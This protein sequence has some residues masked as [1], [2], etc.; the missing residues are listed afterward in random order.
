M[1]GDPLERDSFFEEDG[2]LMTSNE[3][4]RHSILALRDP[5]V[6]RP[7]P[8][9]GGHERVQNYALYYEGVS[10]SL[11]KAHPARAG[12]ERDCEP[13]K[14]YERLSV[15]RAHTM[16]DFEKQI[17]ELKKENFNLK[18][19]IYFLEEQVQR[20]CDNSSEELHRMNI[21]L[22]VEVESLKHEYQEKQTLL[23][24]ASKAM[25]SF[26]GDHN[27]TVQQLKDDH[28]K[29]LQDLQD[30]SRRKAQA[31]EDELKQEKAELEK[32]CVILDQE[33]RQRFN[34]EERL[35]AVKEQYNKSMGI[36]E[37]RD[38]IVQCLNE[39][40]RSKDALITQ[41]EKQMNTMI[42]SDRP[43]AGKE[44]G[45][46]LE[47]DRSHSPGLTCRDC[48][49]TKSS[50]E[51]EDNV[52]EWRKK[53]QE[54]GNVVNELQQKLEDSKA[55][56]AAEEKNSLKRDKAIQ[57]LTL[58]L[59]KKSKE[60]E[61]LRKDIDNLNAASAQARESSLH[62]GSQ[63]GDTDY[64]KLIFTIQAQQ[65]LCSRL[66]QYE[67]ESGSLQKELDAIVM[68]RKWLE[69]DIQSNQEL[70]KILEAQIMERY[71]ESDSMSFLGDQTSYLSI[72]LDHL[73][74]NNHHIDGSVT[75]PLMKSAETQTVFTNSQNEERRYRLQDCKL[76][77][78]VT[79]ENA[80]EE[81]VTAV[82]THPKHE[83]PER[84]QNTASSSIQTEPQFYADRR[85]LADAFAEETSEG[86]KN[87]AKEVLG[88]S[89]SLPSGKSPHAIQ[90]DKQQ[91]CF[92]N[93]LTKS[94]IPVL[95]KSPL[96]KRLKT[97]T[98]LESSRQI[99]QEL[100][101]E[102]P[103]VWSEKMEAGLE[104]SKQNLPGDLQ[105]EKLSGRS[106]QTEADLESSRQILQG[107]IHPERLSGR[108][109]QTKAGL[110]S[111]RLILQGERL[112]GHMEADLTSREHERV[113]LE[114]ELRDENSRLLEELKF[115][116]LEIETLKSIKEKLEDTRQGWNVSQIE[117]W[118]QIL[119]EGL[120][121]ER[122][123]GQGDLQPER[124]KELLAQMEAGLASRESEP[125]CPEREL[126]EENSR[127]LEELKC[128][129]LEIGALKS[130]PEGTS[131]V[132]DVPNDEI[133]SS[134]QI[135]LGE[136]QVEK[137]SSEENSE[138]TEA[139][140][141]SRQNEYAYLEKELREENSRLLE[142]LKF[143]K[144]EIGALK[145]NKEKPES[146]LQGWDVSSPG[147]DSSQFL[148]GELQPERPSGRSEQMEA[149]F[150]CREKEHV[151]HEKELREEN[152]RLLEQLKL[153]KC[154][155]GSLK[156]N[157]EKSEST[158]Q[159]WDVSYSGGIEFSRQ[160]LHGG[161]Q[162]GR[163][164]GQGVL[165]P[166]GLCG[167][168]VLQPMRLNGE[169]GLQP[170]RLSRQGDPQPEA[171]S[172]Q[173][174]LQ[175]EG[176]SEQG[177][178]QPM[179][180]NGQIVLQP[181]RLNEQVGLQPMSLN[182]QVGLQPEGLSEQGG[183]QPERL[184]GQIVLQ[185][186]RL[187]EQVGL[188]PMRLNEQV[189][190]QPERLNG[191]IVLQL[192]RLNGQVG[193]QSKSLNGQ[194][195]LQPERLSGQ[196]SLQPVRLSG[197]GSLQPEGLIGQGGLQP[198]GLNGLPEQFKCSQIKG[199]NLQPV[200][201]SG[202]CT[203][204][205]SDT[206]EPEKEKRDSLQQTFRNSKLAG[207]FKSACFKEENYLSR[208]VVYENTNAKSVL[209]IADIAEGDFPTQSLHKELQVE[210][211]R[212]AEQLKHAQM[213][214]EKH[215][216]REGNLEKANVSNMASGYMLEGDLAMRSRIEELQL[217]NQRLAGQLKRE[218]MDIEK[219][220]ASEVILE[221]TNVRSDLDTLEGDLA[222]RSL[223][224]ELQLENQQL[225]EQ[226]KSA[227]LEIEKLREEKALEDIDGSFR[228]DNP[229][230][231]GRDSEHSFLDKTIGNAVRFSEMHNGNSNFEVQI[232]SHNFTCQNLAGLCCHHDRFCM[233][234]ANN[235]ETLIYQSSSFK[236]ISTVQKE[237]KLLTVS[238]RPF[239]DTSL[240]K[241]DL[242]VQ[243]Q[244]R[245]LSHQRQKI[246]E[247]HNL[248][249]VC[250]KNFINAIKAF[251]DLLS[252]ASLD[253]NIALG[254]QE[255]LAQTVEWLK[256]LEYKLSNAYYGE[257]DANSDH[258]ADSLLYTPSRLVPGHKMWADK[259]GCHVLGLV[260]DYNALR[261]QILESKSVLEETEAFIDHGVQTAVLNMTE[262][263]GNVFFEKL[264]R[265][266][267]SLEEASCLL[268][269]LWRVS[270]P[271][272]T[273]SSYNVR[274]VEES[275][276][277][278]TRLRKRVLEQ[279]KLLSGM[280]KRVYS[281]NQMKE[282]IEK[283][284]LNQLAM[285]HKILKQA[286]GNLEVQVVD[287]N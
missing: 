230:M 157:Q 162:L 121:S 69:K 173:R 35:L 252:T 34:A 128:A 26:A 213:D 138:Q 193:L 238:H 206:E 25:E 114:K 194:V 262:H 43:N 198:E 286:K 208:E 266:K 271:L 64:R 63:N 87:G 244:A 68:L 272:Q 201:D 140:L 106:E 243:S 55:G 145:S 65:D 92:S 62:E 124:L 77:P 142:E 70:R 160:I 116:K 40:L 78:S 53:V 154:E 57:G 161:L 31:L 104:S 19:R 28:L 133:E 12:Y 241:Y 195:G 234:C 246:K 175:P 83:I 137:L 196:G 146:M 38:W 126:R 210:N 20:H 280:V 27:V 81:S 24:R 182:E 76:N 75:R 79:V 71:R 256:E 184:N 177:G 282:D 189:G 117:S 152:S 49:A 29:Q 236:K 214:I 39:T 188:Q 168:V 186:M 200:E 100:Q 119:Q 118:R 139:G 72:C 60:N 240:S 3:M 253:S 30:A 278:T 264:N 96:S 136:L 165:Q 242:L 6:G 281:E 224:K 89:W 1:D 9:R 158:V 277:E 44:V 101:P 130:K 174:D 229:E 216:T 260:E 46:L 265:T 233:E 90:N 181:M 247:S 10:L 11:E 250:S 94:R 150:A 131:Q 21:E 163:L 285:T 255:Q 273:H 261:K 205:P 115:A 105:P 212:L 108:S 23:I 228:L 61:K 183:L 263:F 270:L 59:K 155:I 122:L 111:S 176:L 179:R 203:K 141:A 190:L 48:L 166:E 82:T 120:Q 235:Q 8:V 239:E 191:Q 268:K 279:E 95:L 85:V 219:H 202:K 99:L 245:E 103:S 275:S 135:V 231:D 259:H 276:L 187:N 192:E 171:L 42:P 223:I 227:Q 132:W 199:E 14:G 249:V 143:A 51:Q 50:D 283:L 7:H 5:S 257:D 66:H 269:L 113:C 91:K 36:L 47:S 17:T 109:D 178:L 221:N 15:D 22:K 217:E 204:L 149:G 232:N 54:M 164:S 222:V 258:S 144:L 33:R 267:Q 248:S 2:K 58:A 170:E 13:A 41:L 52:N 98:G 67:R 156:S 167:Q 180:L 127:L 148:Q 237:C 125:I 110:E 197:Q 86:V 45:L 74:E 251:E 207:E 287:K 80:Q 254:F 73:G 134:R 153:A 159:G 169:V 284:I 129:K 16:K 211:L 18:L 226:L 102:R 151:C 112:S 218:Q 107:D 147:I 215:Q 4:D 123:G 97:E 37:E 84:S 220:Q 172:G 56:F 225:L 93:N 32:I 209:D 88:N 274:Q 185:P